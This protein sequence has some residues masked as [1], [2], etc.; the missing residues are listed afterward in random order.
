MKSIGID[1][2]APIAN[3]LLQFHALRPT[4]YGLEM[5]LVKIHHLIA[6]FQPSIAILD[7]ISSLDAAVTLPQVKSFICA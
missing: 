3:G 6:Q 4:L 7:P 5:H 2:T 1:L